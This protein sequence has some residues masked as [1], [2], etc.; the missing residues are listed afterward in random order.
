MDGT[1]CPTVSGI[2]QGFDVRIVQ[3]YRI[4]PLSMLASNGRSHD[5]R[6]HNAHCANCLP[7]HGL[8]KLSAVF[9]A[10]S[11]DL[12]DMVQGGGNLVHVAVS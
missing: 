3:H 2:S 9:T 7:I 11:H 12:A 10:L 1:A 8:D 4:T 5:P 6:A